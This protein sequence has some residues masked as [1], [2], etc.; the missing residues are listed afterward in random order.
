ML[1]HL[2][3]R[4][5]A[6]LLLLLVSSIAHARLEEGLIYTPYPVY[7]EA[8]RPLG[9]LLAD[10]SPFHQEGR[11]FMGN[12]KYQIR[13]HFRLDADASG[14]CRISQL[15]TQ[16]ASTISLPRLVGGTNER[17]RSFVQILTNLRIHELGHV[18]IAS[19]AASAIDQSLAAMPQMASCAALESA[20]NA[21]GY[22][23]LKACEGRQMEYDRVTD[24]GRLQ[25]VWSGH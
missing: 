19:E 23:L 5:C 4:A 16:L 20:A 6:L 21:A 14:R 3:P 12:T 25:S 1:A 24:H 11:N 15:E 22:A 7:N 8:A 10:A 13:W 17:M 2:R 9:R 18:A